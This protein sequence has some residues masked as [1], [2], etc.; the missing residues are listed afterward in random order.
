MP[1]NIVQCNYEDM[2]K[3]AAKFISE[4]NETQA[5]IQ[6]LKQAVDLL[7]DGGWIGVGADAFYEEMDSF[8]FPNLDKLV[9]ALEQAEQKTKQAVQKIH[10]TED[11]QANKW[12][13]L[14]SQI[15]QY[16]RNR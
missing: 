2:D 6:K 10:D 4:S 5:T 16:V 12:K 9:Q 8:V 11:E 7:R 3:I 13:Q 1:R 15:K 14:Q